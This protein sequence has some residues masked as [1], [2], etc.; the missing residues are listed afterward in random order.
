MTFDPR[1]I[2]VSA[3]PTLPLVCVCVCVCVCVWTTKDS[4]LLMQQSEHW[5]RGNGLRGN[6]VCVCVCS[7]VCVLLCGWGWCNY[8]L[9]VMTELQQ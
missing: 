2:V 6:G 1:C 9:V 8:V 4:Q 7:Y 3:A 5:K